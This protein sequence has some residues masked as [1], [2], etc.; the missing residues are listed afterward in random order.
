VLFKV[1]TIDE[2]VRAEMNVTQHT[3]IVIG[4]PRQRQ[5]YCVTSFHQCS[6]PLVKPDT[7]TVISMH[8]GNIP[9]SHMDRSAESW[10]YM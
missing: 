3:S 2:N 1:Y 10:E 4:D 6:I 7:S 8:E 9:R 5:H